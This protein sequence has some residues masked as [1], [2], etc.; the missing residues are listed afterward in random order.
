MVEP[1]VILA[2]GDLVGIDVEAVKILL[3]Y[4]A[5]NLLL[6]DPWQLPQI[7]MAE[8]HKLGAAKDGY[9]LTQ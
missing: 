8:K 5:R 7:M 2:S 9:V 1:G 6:S 4:K 3:S